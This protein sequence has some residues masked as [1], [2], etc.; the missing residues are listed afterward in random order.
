MPSTLDVA[1]QRVLGRSGDHI[2]AGEPGIR[3]QCDLL[4]SLFGRSWFA[5]SLNRIAGHPAFQRWSL[6]QK[7][8]EQNC[9]LRLPQDRPHVYDL[10]AM[11]LDH[12]IVS[13]CS[14]GDL[15]RFVLG[16]FLGYG[17]ETVRRRIKSIINNPREFNSLMTQFSF[18]AGHKEK[19]HDIEPFE[20]DGAPDF[21][22]TS[23][24]LPLPIIAECKTISRGSSPRRYKK[25]IGKANQQIKT[26][27]E[28]AYGVAVIDVT[29]Q[30]KSVERT[31]GD[32]SV[33]VEIENATT[34]IRQSLRSVNTSVSAVILQWDTFAI[35]G[36]SRV[37]TQGN[38][39]DRQ[40]AAIALR[41]F[42]RI[43]RHER[44]LIA[45]PDN[46]DLFQCGYSVVSLLLLGKNL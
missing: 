37:A 14:G 19:G 10:A 38:A 41:R 20:H 23:S 36:N 11:M 5:S 17:D 43:I 42:N 7:L 46:D 1:I 24:S 16:D 28:K 21:R 32:N 45:L 12:S 2:D 25:V 30:Q 44:P 13:K 26:L 6:C 35:A 31:V 33:P 9:H 8:L 29:Q 39:M 22:I 40:N 18:A 15:G 27:N 34:L 4:I 3:F